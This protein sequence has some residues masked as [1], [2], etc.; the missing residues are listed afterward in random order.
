MSNASCSHGT[1]GSCSQTRMFLMLDD[2]TDLPGLVWNNTGK[3]SG[4]ST[5]NDITSDTF[6]SVGIEIDSMV[7]DWATSSEN[8]SAITLSM[9]RKRYQ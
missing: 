1:E 7:P 5:I 9:P 2:Q 8:F 6:I 3:R 4:S